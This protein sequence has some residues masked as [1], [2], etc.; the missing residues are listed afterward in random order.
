MDHGTVPL[1]YS[2]VLLSV[3]LCTTWLKQVMYFFVQELHVSHPHRK[4]ISWILV[5]LLIK[6]VEKVLRQKSNDTGICAF[7]IHRM[8]FSAAR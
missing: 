4:L 6:D 2:N 7:T 5:P 1:V 3:A 8:F